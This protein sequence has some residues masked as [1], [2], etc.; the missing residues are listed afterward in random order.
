[1]TDCCEKLKV[2]KTTLAR[3]IPDINTIYEL[4]SGI[5]IYYQAQYKPI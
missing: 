5:K 1:M 4:K 2:A 3:R